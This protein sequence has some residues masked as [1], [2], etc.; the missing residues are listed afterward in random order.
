M[1]KIILSIMV[2][3]IYGIAWSAPSWTLKSES[4]IAGDMK[5]YTAIWVGW[6]DLGEYKWKQYG[7]K[8]QDE[9]TAVIGELN[10]KSMPRYLDKYISGK[11][12][13]VAKSKTDQ[14]DRD[15]L[16]VKFDGANYNYDDAVI[17][18]TVNFIDGKT[19]KLLYKA[20]VS[21]VSKIV[22]SPWTGLVRSQ[23]M[24]A[25]LDIGLK[26]LAQF[27]SEKV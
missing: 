22:W 5:N 7:Y 25:R 15:G 18:V 19:D 12:I 16:V 17:D 9:W 4:P 24:E 10:R 3:I 11:K 6:L 14:P 27:I 2:L 8:N 20:N 13:T 1:K 23:A 26:N 21:I